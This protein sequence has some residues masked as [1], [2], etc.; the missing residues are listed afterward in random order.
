MEEVRSQLKSPE[1]IDFGS[2]GFR[3]GFMR[4]IYKIFG[5]KDER[6]G[7]RDVSSEHRIEMWNRSWLTVVH[8]MFF[9]EEWRPH[10]SFL[11]GVKRAIE[12]RFKGSSKKN[13]ITY[14]YYMYDQEHGLHE[15][16]NIGLKEIFKQG[17]IVVDLGCGY[18]AAAY[19]MAAMHP[20]TTIIGGDYEMGK[21]ISIP[22]H[23][24]KNLT[25]HT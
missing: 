7:A 9:D 14:K 2:S 23:S 1:V 17:N 5:Q 16:I 4:A 22:H 15:D 6:R 21:K 8:R 20:G 19:G 10:V 11:D 13:G 25:L 3:D 12:D 18:G 24:L